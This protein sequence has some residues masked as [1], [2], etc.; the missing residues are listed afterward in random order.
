MWEKLGN[1]DSPH[2]FSPPPIPIPHSI[3]PCANSYLEYDPDK[4]LNFYLF[5][6]PCHAV[7]LVLDPKQLPTFLLRDYSPTL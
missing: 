4:F 2:P 3:F 1:F 6:T 5:T 7:S